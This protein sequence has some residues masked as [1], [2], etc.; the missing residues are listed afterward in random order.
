LQA[1]FGALFCRI[2]TLGQLHEPEKVIGGSR[3]GQR[4]IEGR[5]GAA[6]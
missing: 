1:E 3:R 4:R 6:R 2:A 5:A